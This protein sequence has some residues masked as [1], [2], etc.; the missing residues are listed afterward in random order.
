MVWPNDPPKGHPVSDYY[1]TD[2]SRQPQGPVPLDTLRAMANRGELPPGC[3]V[4]E[5]G[6]DRWEA[7]AT[8]IGGVAPPV[9][10]T[11]DIGQDPNR[12]EPLAG[13]AFGLG[14]AS[15]ACLNIFGAIPAI[16][17]GHMALGRIK[18]SRCTN[19]SAKVLAIIGLVAAYLNIALTLAYVVVMVVVFVGALASGASGP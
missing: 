2:A 8:V 14:M 12:F 19:S 4:A 11:A 9:L 3:L 18:A 1:F 16:I 7:A 13:W 17:L 15:W 6:A 10:P 5:V